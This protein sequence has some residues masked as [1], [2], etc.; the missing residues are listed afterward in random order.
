MFRRPRRKWRYCAVHQHE[1]D[2]NGS[3]DSAPPF[4]PPRA[5]AA[6]AA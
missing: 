3:S 1:L 2:A 5:A 4:A 6:A